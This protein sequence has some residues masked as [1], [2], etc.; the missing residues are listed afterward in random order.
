MRLKDYANKYF[1]ITNGLRVKVLEKVDSY[2]SW[3]VQCPTTGREWSINHEFFLKGAVEI[4]EEQA[5]AQ[6]ATIKEGVIQGAICSCCDWKIGKKELV[7]K[8]PHKLGKV[9]YD[10]TSRIQQELRKFFLLNEPLMPYVYPTDDGIEIQFIS[11]KGMLDEIT[12]K[13]NE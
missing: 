1:L 12:E 5:K 8:M 6:Y 3:M 13:K 10:E 9:P 2:S 4:T 7:L 11:Q